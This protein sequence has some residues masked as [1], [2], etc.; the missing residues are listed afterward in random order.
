MLAKDDAACA[1]SSRKEKQA[2][3][4]PDG[5]VEEQD[6]KSIQCT[7]QAAHADHVSADLPPRID[8][9]TDDFCYESCHNYATEEHRYIH[10]CHHH[11][12]CGIADER[13][14]VRHVT[15]LAV[16]QLPMCPLLE[17]SEQVDTHVRDEYS[18]YI[19]QHKDEYL[20]RPR[21]HAQVAETEK[22]KDYPQRA[23]Q[24]GKKL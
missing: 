21:Q 10:F 9:D 22:T 2:A 19:D 12:T 3:E 15:M 14:N 7:H 4:R 18:E 5:I 17:D 11:K 24:W 20:I 23:I 8:G 6:A 16:A 1:K 13:H